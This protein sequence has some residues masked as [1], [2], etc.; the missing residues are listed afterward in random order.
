MDSNEV[1]NKVIGRY[2]T[3]IKLNVKLM[4]ESSVIMSLGSVKW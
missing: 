2:R 1:M 3:V 4:E